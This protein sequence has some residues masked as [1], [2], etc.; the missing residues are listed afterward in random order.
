MSQVIR[1]FAIAHEI[2]LR[3]LLFLLIRD[4]HEGQPSLQHFTD[5]G[6]IQFSSGS[7]AI[8][9]FIKIVKFTIL[10][11]CSFFWTKFTIRAGS[12][13]SELSISHA[14]VD[15]I[16]WVTSINQLNAFPLPTYMPSL[17]V[18]KFVSSCYSCA[19]SRSPS[20]HNFLQVSLA[21]EM[22]V[23]SASIHVDVDN[24]CHNTAFNSILDFIG[25]TQ[26]LN[27]PTHSFNHTFDLVLIQC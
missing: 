14:A 26:S 5:L 4:N 9:D 1:L 2:Q 21:S 12:G 20:H 8:Q 17:H 19:S 22:Y 13:D 10:F 3:G 15:L 27:K 23:S 25:F 24:N 6:F 18:I 16:C 11:S 7:I